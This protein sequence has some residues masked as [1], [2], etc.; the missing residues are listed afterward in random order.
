M[1]PGYRFG[2]LSYSPRGRDELN[3]RVSLPSDGTHPRFSSSYF[4]LPSRRMESVSPS[5][6]AQ[7]PTYPAVRSRLAGTRDLSSS[8][9]PTAPSP[10]FPSQAFSTT[11][12]STLHVNEQASGVS[13]TGSE[14]E[15]PNLFSCP[16][17]NIAVRRQNDT[18]RLNVMRSGSR[19]SNLGGHTWRQGQVPE[20]IINSARDEDMHG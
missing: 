8:F 16:P 19:P 1:T 15:L 14:H 6:P 12:D 2:D 11:R 7:E 5:L 18:P 4:A 9:V 20:P 3:G 17:P 13:A 10:S